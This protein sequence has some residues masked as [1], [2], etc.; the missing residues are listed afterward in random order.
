[1]KRP[2]A[3]VLLLAACSTEADIEPQSGAWSYNGSTLVM[4]SCGD[5]PPTDAVGGFTLTVTG[6]GKFTVNDNTFTNPFECSY[7]GDSFTCPKRLADSNKPVDSLDATVS[8]NVSITGTLDS[9]M[10]L[11]GTQTVDVSC[12]GTGCALSG[13]LLGFELPCNY[14]YKF[15]ADAT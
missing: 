3:L 9:E 6:P 14:S 13:P 15:T 5:D 11:S 10:A 4:S 7:E 12:E 2:L 1:M 8:Y